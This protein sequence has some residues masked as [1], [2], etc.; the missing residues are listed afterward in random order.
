MS[1]LLQLQTMFQ[2]YLLS[3]QS[4]IATCIIQ[5]EKVSATKRLDI[6]LDAYQARLMECLTSNYP[7]FKHYVGLEL[8]EEIGTAYLKKYPSSFRSIRWFGDNFSSYLQEHYKEQPQL[9]EF[10]QF[11][12]ALTLAFDAPDTALFTIEEMAAISP[13]YWG[14]L[15]FIPHPS[16][17]QLQC[18][19]NVVPIWQALAKEQQSE[20]LTTYD[21]PISWIV[22]R[23]DYASR[24]CSLNDDEAWAMKAMMQGTSF[25]DI[26]SGLCEWYSEEEVG[27]QAASLLKKW[28]QL[29]L[30]AGHQ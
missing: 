13:E 9:C 27:L 19:W 30:L 10:A 12:W 26:C 23:S 5:S 25:G 4:D 24:F 16:L 1:N 22:W 8:F 11:E 14:E 18:H 3:G 6:Y 28:I 21:Q 7:V 17:Q 15:V 2:N 20:A 29:G